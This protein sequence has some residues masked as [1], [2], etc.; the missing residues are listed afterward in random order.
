MQKLLITLSLVLISA[1]VYS[2]EKNPE[3]ID[4]Q[5]GELVKIHNN[6]I[7]FSTNNSSKQQQLSFTNS[8]IQNESDVKSITVKYYYGKED[9]LFKEFVYKKRK[10]KI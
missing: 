10:N 6:S 9:T 4:S 3:L 1:Y 8:S 2:Q 7:G 5:K